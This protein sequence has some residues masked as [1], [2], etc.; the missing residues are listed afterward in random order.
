MVPVPI[1][2]PGKRF[3]RFRF[4]FRFREERFRRF[5]FP[6]PVWFLSHPGYNDNYINNCRET[7]FLHVPPFPIAQSVNYNY[8]NNISASLQLQLL[9]GPW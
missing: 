4:C 7:C 1:S 8:I 6:V 5:W 2:V 3:R 9:R